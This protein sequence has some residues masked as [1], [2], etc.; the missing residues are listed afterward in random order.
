[1]SLA[2]QIR[3]KRLEK[4]LTQDR[5]AKDVGISRTMIAHYESGIKLPNIVTGV[6]LAK[7][8]G[9]TTEALVDE[10]TNKNLEN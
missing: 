2:E 4:G 8:L 6:K 3:Q 10:T 5:L 1:M 7:I 9:T